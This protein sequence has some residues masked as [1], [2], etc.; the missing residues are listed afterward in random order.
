MKFVS[1]GLA[2][3]GLLL[4]TGVAAEERDTRTTGVTYQDLDLS[5]EEGRTEL[6]RR[7]DNAAKTVCGVNEREV[8]SNIMSRESRACYRNAKR[9]LER[10]FAQVVEERS[11]AGR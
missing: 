5:T 9:E 11:R 10:H 8:G 3:A 1:I 7:I 4:S 6:A 2:C